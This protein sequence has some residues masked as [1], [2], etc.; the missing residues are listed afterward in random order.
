MQLIY[1][2]KKFFQVFQQHTVLFSHTF[3]GK[4]LCSTDVFKQK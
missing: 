4:T 3:A 1:T 2:E